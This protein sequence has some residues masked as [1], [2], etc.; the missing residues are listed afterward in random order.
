MA[1]VYGQQMAALGR[2]YLSVRL[3]DVQDARLCS[4]H[5]VW[6]TQ[7]MSA[8]SARVNLARLNVTLSMV[9]QLY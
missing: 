4:E 6:L 3:L 9:R 1:Q 2:R 8:C 7:N 5:A